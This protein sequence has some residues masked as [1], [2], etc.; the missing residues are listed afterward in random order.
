M[1]TNCES[2]YNITA[3][4]NEFEKL[5]ERLGEFINEANKRNSNSTGF[6]FNNFNAT[7]HDEFIKSNLNKKNK[8]CGTKR[9]WFETNPSETNSSETKRFRFETNPVE[10]RPVLSFGSSIDKNKEM[11]ITNNQYNELVAKYKDE[12]IKSLDRKISTCIRIINKLQ[13]N[14]IYSFLCVDLLKNPLVEYDDQERILKNMKNTFPEKIPDYIEN[15]LKPSFY[16]IDNIKKVYN[17]NKMRCP[18]WYDK[19][20]SSIFNEHKNRMITM[21][22]IQMEKLIEEKS[23]L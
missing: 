3:G 9:S 1:A 11:K 14:Y 16:H 12:K 20:Y 8:N 10:T 21:I 13:T 18:E 6:S 2:N 17:L 4:L 15:V 22:N 5:N 19:K 23:N 7:D